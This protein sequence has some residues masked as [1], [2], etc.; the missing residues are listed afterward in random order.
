MTM[1][2]VTINVPNS[3]IGAF[4]N[5]IKLG[6]YNSRSQIVREALKDFLD[7]EKAFTVDLQSENFTKIKSVQCRDF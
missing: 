7:K 1:R 3:Y 6:L 5:L 4:E 2:I